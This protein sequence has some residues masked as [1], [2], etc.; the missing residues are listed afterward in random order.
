MR[1]SLLLAVLASFTAALPAFAQARQVASSPTDRGQ[2]QEQTFFE[3]QVEKPAESRP[4]NPRPQ[5]PFAL[6]SRARSGEVTAEFVVDTTG[7]VDMST[8]QVVKSTD[9]AFSTSVRNAVAA[10]RFYPAEIAGHKVRELAQQ[11][12]VFAAQ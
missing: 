12:F 2:T 8:F 3:F 6:L 4:G 1:R 11:H 10:M 9:N 5:Y 7:R